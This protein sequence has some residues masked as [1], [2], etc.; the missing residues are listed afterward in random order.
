MWSRYPIVGPPVHPMGPN[1]IQK[2]GFATT[3]HV[4]DVQLVEGKSF[5]NPNF[6]NKNNAFVH[7]YKNHINMEKNNHREKSINSSQIFDNKKNSPESSSKME[8]SSNS[9]QPQIIMM[10]NNDTNASDNISSRT[11]KP[12]VL[13]GII[14]GCN[15]DIDLNQSN[16]DRN[17]C[18]NSFV[19]PKRERQLSVTSED[20][21]IIFDCDYDE[22]D[23]SYEEENDEEDELNDDNDI[24]NEIEH[25]D[26]VCTKPTTKKVRLETILKMWIS[27][28]IA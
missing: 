13:S 18:L 6:V 16:C 19:T 21:F 24:D 25:N 27:L 26:V 7:N 14:F 4:P 10:E 22:S 8:I 15:F 28:R 1:M 9:N 17:K 23:N 2:K 5:S 20:N 12:I 3:I 11:E